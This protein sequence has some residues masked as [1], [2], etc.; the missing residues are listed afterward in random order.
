ML[1][2]LPRILIECLV[3]L[4]L[5]CTGVLLWASYYIDTGEFRARFT[6]T[7]EAILARP[8]T[9]EG[10]LDIAIWPRLALTVEDLAIGEAPGFGD[11]PAARFDD[12]DISVRIIPLLSRRIEVD[13]L[14]L[15]GV[16]GVLVRDKAGVFNW[17]SMLERSGRAMS[18]PSPDQEW[19]FAVDSVE[20]TDAEILFRDEMAGT[21]YK[22]SGIDIHTGTVTLGEDVPFSLRSDFS[23]ADQGIKADLVLKGMVR[24][25]DDGTPPVFS[26]ASVQARV[27]GD[28][29]PD[30]AE[31]GEFIARM[32]LDWDKRTVAFED[33]KASLFGLLAE[34]DMTSGDLEKGLDFR[35]H[36][37][38]HPFAPRRLIAQY[39]PDLPIKDVDGLNSS[40]LASYV[41]VTEDGASFENLILTL[42]DI[43]V[44][45]QC[46]FKDWTR[47]VFDFA[48]R[49]DTI[50]L[51]NYLPL[52]RTGT[53]FVWDDFSLP[54]FR[55]FRGSG[56]IRADGFDVLDTLVSDIRLNV[57]ATDRGIAFDAG[58]IR[59]GL[60]SLGGSMTVV[61]GEA[62]K[63]EPTLALNG[64]LDAESQRRGFEFLHRTPVRFDGPGTAHLEFSVPA[65]SCPPEVRSI[66]ILQHLTGLVRL[67]LGQGRAEA[68]RI[69]GD[70][71]SLE[72]SKADLELKVRPDGK[73]AKGV[74]NSV[75]SAGLKLRSG[76]DLES[77]NVTAEGPFS[78]AVDELRAKSSGMAVNGYLT[79]SLLPK[80]ASRLTFGGKVA[81]DSKGGEAALTDTVIQAFETTL[82]GDARLAGG[83]KD[84]R[85]E[86]SLSVAQ[87]DPKRIVYLLTGEN[88]RTRDTDAL[89]S[90][91][92]KTRF[93]ADGEGFTLSELSGEL[94]GTPV[95][96]HVVATGYAHPLFAFS[97]AAGSFNLDRYLTPAPA[98]TLSDV[99]EGR[100][101]ESTPTDLP[102]EF[103]RF[104]KLNGKVL[105]QEFTLAR[106]RSES[107]EGFVRANEGAI[108]LAEVQ[109]RIHGGTLKADLEGQADEKALDL[110]LVL[111]VNGMQAG[112]FME[113]MAEREYLRGETD[114]KAD[115]YSVGR[116]DDD[117]LANLDGTASLRITNGS[118]KFT[119]WD[120]KPKQANAGRTLQIGA[121]VQRKTEGRTTFRRASSEATVKQGV[122][123]L[124]Q[125]RLE[126]PPVLQSYGEG[127]FSLPANTIDLS[128]RNDFVA[129]PSVTLHLTGKLTD[130]KVEVPT[131]KI[132]N[133]T[134]LNILSLPKKSF[135]F[136]RDL[137]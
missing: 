71:L 21:E 86:G 68:R 98:P 125:F 47:P 10:D 27:Y 113:D 91:S 108:H 18:G 120:L 6:Q 137:F 121:D 126:A 42:D 88:I 93:K 3:A 38:V 124:D 79:T 11:G 43:T 8:V 9:L 70:P 56:T 105:F 19:T 46:G 48:L 62:G 35:G 2:R 59:E 54:F 100:E 36:I 31:P 60:A 135:E 118:F 50:D 101:P 130:P 5:V 49:A 34:G 122:F 33:F 81:F 104:L 132:V 29:L 4:I 61:L 106:V 83:A 117:I 110:H 40:A 136:L 37:T 114:I 129:V 26:Q 20:I 90:A 45:G 74:W 77:V 102:L 65:M 115:L 13:S 28:F 52:F 57:D 95:K 116:T 87:A 41:H 73:G 53:P 66:Y 16:E 94:D 69:K 84:R 22:L 39:A 32:D 82:A 97:L 109:G 75:L 55:A 78:T 12:I 25:M 15:A 17:Q 44:R 51:D 76:G 127:G 24:V 103:L 7:L 96:G 63:G 99:R 112:P 89:R 85:V 23:W 134:V 64:V 133:D 80:A 72:Y 92:L 1:K 58:A 123:T 107:L 128:I 14:D 67:S 119:G 111:D 131:G 30:K